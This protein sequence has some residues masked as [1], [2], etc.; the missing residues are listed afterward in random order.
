M[1]QEMRMMLDE[2]LA[3]AILIGDGRL[4]S[5]PEKIM[6]EHIRPVWSD[7]EMYTIHKVIAAA[8]ASDYSGMIDEIVRARKAYK[9]SGNPVMFIG[10]DILTEMRLLKD[11]DNRMRYKSDQELAEVMRVSA[12]HEV[13]LFDSAVRTVSGKDRKLVCLVLNLADYTMGAT[14]GGEVNLFDDFDLDYNKYEYLIETRVSGALTMPKS[15]I[16]V[17]IQTATDSVSD[18]V[19]VRVTTPVT[20]DIADYYEIDEYGRYFSTSDAAVVSGKTYYEVE[21]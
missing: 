2:E 11:N 8:N 9:G 20:E 5:D 15:A 1:K 14:K 17:E 7:D 12:I 19:Y 16:A 6:P 3:R 21:E 18:P 4:T 10:S 13:E